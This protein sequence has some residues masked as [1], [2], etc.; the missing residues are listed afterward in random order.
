MTKEAPKD[1]GR[2]KYVP[3][4]FET[5]KVFEVNAPTCGKCSSG[6]TGG[7]SCGRLRRTS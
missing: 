4:D 3:P 6:P 7:F 1:T 2:K 5:E